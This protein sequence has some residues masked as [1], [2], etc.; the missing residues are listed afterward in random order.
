MTNQHISKKRAIIIFLL[1]SFFYFYQM[2]LQVSPDVL[3]PYLMEKFSVTE[4][5]LGMLTSAYFFA[6]MLM[7]I[8]VGILLDRWGAHRML[9]LASCLC[10]LGSFLF[11]IA[12]HFYI[13]SLSRL[14]IG[15]GAAFAYIGG[16]KLVSNWFPGQRFSLMMGLLS[17]IGMF[18]GIIG[19]APLAEVI[20]QIGWRESMFC[21]G[22]IGLAISLLM[23]F[24][25]RETPFSVYSEKQDIPTLSK[26][27]KQEVFHNKQ[28]W[29]ASFYESIISIPPIIL[30]SLYGVPF[31]KDKYGLDE[32]TASRIIS[33]V[34]VGFMVSGPFWGW[35]S[36]YIKRRLPP[37]YAA[38]IG[39]PVILFLLIYFSFPLPIVGLLLFSLGFFS[40]GSITA[41]STIHEITRP[42][43]LGTAL[44]M[45]NMFDDLGAAFMLPIF[46]RLLGLFGTPTY[47]HSTYTYAL[48]DY[49]HVFMILIAIMIIPIILLRFI[50]ETYAKSLYPEEEIEYH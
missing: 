36:D 46:G 15:V 28:L 42:Q 17:T 40:Y 6:Y 47:S 9:S 23:L 13:A 26:Q 39:S 4:H 30:T 37:M 14:L 12:P 22:L 34:F 35:F 29:F 3:G 33:I 10:A 44:G 24:F 18:G 11:S 49:Q 2:I 16:L 45:L 19:E 50:K 25:I 48:T 32:V 43:Y 7:Q 27:Q 20:E 41:F 38:A 31:L 21:L 1:A 5:R 8:P